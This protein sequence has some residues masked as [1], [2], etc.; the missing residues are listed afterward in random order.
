MTFMS[1][2]LTCPG[3]R[4]WSRTWPLA[5]LI[6]E[7]ASMSLLI[8]LFCRLG[9][10]YLAAPPM[11]LFKGISAEQGGHPVAQKFNKTTLPHRSSRRTTL[12]LLSTALLRCQDSSG[13]RI[14]VVQQVGLNKWID[15]AVEHAIGVADFDIGTVIF[16]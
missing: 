14:T 10:D 9:G 13:R 7:S 11:T 1:S 16:D 15:I 8:V 4:R 12:P 6:L 3:W 2:P 5:P